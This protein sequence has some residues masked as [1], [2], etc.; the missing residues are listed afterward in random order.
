MTSKGRVVAANEPPPDDMPPIPLMVL[1]SLADDIETIDTMRNCGDAEPNGL[2]LVGETFILDALRCLV[3]DRLIEPFETV[4]GLESGLTP[5]RVAEPQPTTTT[6][7]P[8]G[9][10]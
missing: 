7:A 3:A 4:G 9:S 10:G 1:D 8:I 6:S 2:A 5:R